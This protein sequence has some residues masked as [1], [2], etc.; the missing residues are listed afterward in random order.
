MEWKKEQQI[1]ER[2]N[3]GSFYRF[4]NSKLS[5][6]RGLGALS[7]STGGVIVGEAERADLLN[8]Y[9]SSVYDW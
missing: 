8:S 7:K 1:I 4:V 5:C 6:K 2:Y 3:A 9:F